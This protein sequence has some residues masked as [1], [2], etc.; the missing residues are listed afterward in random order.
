LMGT[1]WRRIA[2]RWEKVRSGNRLPQCLEDGARPPNCDIGPK[3]GDW[4]LGLAL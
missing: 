1:A 3:G 4:R 2:R